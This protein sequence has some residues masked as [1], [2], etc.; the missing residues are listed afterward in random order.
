MLTHP[1]TVVS[2]A[3]YHLKLTK[4]AVNALSSPCNLFKLSSAESG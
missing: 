4:A 2:Y 3:K 1:Q